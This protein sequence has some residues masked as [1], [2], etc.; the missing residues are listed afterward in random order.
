MGCQEQSQVY[1][2]Q[3][4]RRCRYSDPFWRKAAFDPECVKTLLGLVLKQRW[5][6]ERL[7]G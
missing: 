3:S 6:V 1:P 7:Y 2:L 5:L 4:V